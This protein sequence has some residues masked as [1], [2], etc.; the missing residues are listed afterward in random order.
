MNILAWII[1]GI[2][3][4]WIAEQVTKSSMGILMNLV[5]GV[6]GAFVGG[7]IFSL[8]GA[9]GVSG[10]SIWSL[11]VATVGAIVLVLIV[12]AVRKNT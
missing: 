7:F 10:F 5:V 4:G 2:A 9:D 1:I 8:L 11:I 6:V 12:N 3:A